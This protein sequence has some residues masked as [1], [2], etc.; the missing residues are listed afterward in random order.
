[1]RVFGYLDNHPTGRIVIDPNYHDRTKYTPARRENWDELYPDATEDIPVD[2]PTPKGKEVKLAI[3]VDAY[4]ARDK[5]TRQYV[6]GI[7][8][9][10]NN[11]PIRF[12]CKRRQTVEMSTYGSEMVAAR[13]AVE[14]I[15]ELWYIL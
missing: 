10:I 5:V 4:H 14:T 1:M 6:T 2:M 3:F 7:L 11:T 9:L 12:C 15:L 13:I 8:I